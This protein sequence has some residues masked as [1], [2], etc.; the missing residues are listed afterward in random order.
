M[1]YRLRGRCHLEI[2]RRVDHVAARPAW[3]MSHQT[4]RLIKVARDFVGLDDFT[5]STE[6][7]MTVAIC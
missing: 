6:G 4:G 2:V 3:R 1:A 7:L 5:S